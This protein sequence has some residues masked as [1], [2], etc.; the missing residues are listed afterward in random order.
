MNPTDPRPG[1]RKRPDG[2]CF[3]D[4]FMIRFSRIDKKKEVFHEKT[5]GFR[6]DLSAFVPSPG[7]RAGE[8]RRQ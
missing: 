5:M 4:C 3:L 2:G 1:Q 7:L 8:A 6:A